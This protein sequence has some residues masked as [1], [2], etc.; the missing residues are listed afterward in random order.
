MQR[1]SLFQNTA[2]KLS[3]LPRVQY[4]S[5]CQTV[6]TVLKIS[7]NVRIGDLCVSHGVTEAKELAHQI[8]KE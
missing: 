7:P 8:L 3:G 4:M 2:V 5:S 1:L 6:N